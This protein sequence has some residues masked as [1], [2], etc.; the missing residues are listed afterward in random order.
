MMLISDV[1]SEHT[2]VMSI[3]QACSEDVVIV[4][5]VSVTDSEGDK[6]LENVFDTDAVGAGGSDVIG[7]DIK[8]TVEHD[9]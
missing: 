5:F 7:A 8:G 2:V 4:A 9:I 1:E 6:F 3:S